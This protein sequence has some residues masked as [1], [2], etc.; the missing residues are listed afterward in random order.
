MTIFVNLTP[1][2]PRADPRKERL[3]LEDSQTCPVKADVLQNR[4][5][6]KELSDC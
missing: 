3:W 4:L 2:T 5:F 6:S 1:Q